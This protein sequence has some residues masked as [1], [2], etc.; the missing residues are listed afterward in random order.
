MLWSNF[1]KTSSS[2]SK[3]RRYFRQM[4]RQ[5]YFFNHNIGPR[6]GEFSPIGRLFRY[7]GQSV[8]QSLKNA[9]FWSYF[10]PRYKLC[11]N[12]WR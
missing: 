5:K 12:F 6:L 4:F 3:K 10:F 9:G 11:N 1:C 7:F 2:L 8:W